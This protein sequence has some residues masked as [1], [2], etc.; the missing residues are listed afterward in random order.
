[1]PSSKVS[2]KPASRSILSARRALQP[3]QNRSP[4]S[5]LRN[6]FCNDKI[7]IELVELAQATKQIRRRFA[8]LLFLAQI[9]NC[10]EA[11]VVLDRAPS[12]QRAALIRQRRKRP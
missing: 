8:K 1:M 2:F 10:N 6:L 7:D 3:I 5:L 9:S 4:E 11:L 12:E